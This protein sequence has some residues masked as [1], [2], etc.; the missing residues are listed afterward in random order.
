MANNVFYFNPTCELAVANGSFSYMPPRLLRQFESDCSVLPFIFGTPGDFVLTDKKPSTDFIH[1]LTDAGFEMPEFCSPE[2]L[3]SK[4]P[5]SINSILPWGWSPAAHFFLKD[6]KAKCSHEFRE[7]SVF[8]WTEEH[9]TLYERATSLNFLNDFLEQK[10]LDFFIKKALTGLKIA[11]PEEI[12]NLLKRQI[13]LVLKAPLSS[14]GRGIQIIRKPVL[15]A[16][17]SQWISGVIKQQKYLIAE[18]FLDKI[19]DFSFQFN[20]SNAGDPEYLGYSVFETN[21]N[22]Q[23]KSTFIRP[24]IW[25]HHFSEIYPQTA[26]MIR[27]TAERLTEALR[28]TVYTKLHSGFLGIDAMIYRDGKGLKIQPCIEINSRMNMGILTMFIEKKIDE[29]TTGKFELFYGAQGDFQRF[30]TEKVAKH[31]LKMK[32]GKLSSGFLSLVEPTPEKQFGAYII[33]R[34]GND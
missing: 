11:N 16:S 20:I 26:E 23:Y 19:A 34:S 14:S 4:Q 21:S 3:I 9:K 5:D 17:N 6:L 24:E 22:G 27:E 18:P 7:S 15:N 13:P 30:A 1:R 25:E 33:L 32:N 8:S 2:E 12:E 10:P 29:G 31:P 28:H